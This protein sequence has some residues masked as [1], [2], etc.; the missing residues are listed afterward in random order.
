MTYMDGDAATLSEEVEAF[1]ITGKASR[2]P[3]P[4]LL[5]A[6][7]RRY[8]G[9]VIMPNMLMNLLDDHVVIHTLIPVEPSRTTVICDWLFDPMIMRRPDFDPMD[10]VEL[11]D[12]VN[13][14]DWEVCEWTQLSMRSKAYKSGGI[15]VPAE[16]HIRELADFILEEIG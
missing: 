10:A 4:G 12:I 8:Y 1:T 6:D 14:Q 9:I 11:F 3:L 16:R 5:P 13:R 15:Y 7:R 2:P